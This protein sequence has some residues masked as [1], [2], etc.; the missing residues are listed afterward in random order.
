M[1]ILMASLTALGLGATAAAAQGD[2]SGDGRHIGR[3][4]YE[5]SCMVCHGTGGAGD[6]PLA[7]LMAVEVP[8]LTGLAERNGGSFPYVRTMQV[9]DGRA[10]VRGHGDRMP[11]WGARYLLETAR[12]LDDAAAELVVRGRINAL[13]EYIESIQR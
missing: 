6:G 2:G 11:T 5:N 13:V 1:R 10:D 12:G 9:I 8:D 7:G 4:E 3:I